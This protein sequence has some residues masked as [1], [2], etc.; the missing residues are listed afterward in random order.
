MNFDY[1]AVSAL[2]HSAIPIAAGAA[3][4]AYY[5]MRSKGIGFNTSHLLVGLPMFVVG[6]GAAAL[7]YFT[8][9]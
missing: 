6:A 8:S 5:I 2:L 7:Y 4:V 1:H 9:P 3:G